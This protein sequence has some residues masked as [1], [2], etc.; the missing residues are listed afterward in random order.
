MAVND[1]ALVSFLSQ[2]NKRQAMIGKEAKEL[3]QL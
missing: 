3:M 1:K 2:A